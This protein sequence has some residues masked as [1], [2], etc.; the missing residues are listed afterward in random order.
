MAVLPILEAPNPAL[1]TPAAPVPE[2]DGRLRRLVADLLETMYLAPGIGL[3]APQVGVPSRLFVV[4]IA[5]KEKGEAPAP[6]ALINPVVLWRSA[7]IVPAEEGCLSLP[8]HFAE[9][10]RP[11]GVRLAFTDEH[12]QERE[13]EA[14]GLLARCLQ[15]EYDHLDGVLFTDHLS[16][17]KR[18]M[19]MRKMVKL[20]RGRT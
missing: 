15:H 6:M 5:S 14:R 18:D 3:A 16:P 11:D 17:L 20:R 12:G 4:D 7:M 10:R 13:I 2:V 19:I 9:V 1:K 8:G